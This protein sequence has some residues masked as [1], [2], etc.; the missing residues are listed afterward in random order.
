M[1]VPAGV[2]EVD[3]TVAVNGSA[4]D[5]TIPFTALHRLPSATPNLETTLAPGELITGFHV[6]AGPWTKRSLYLKIRDRQSYEFA[7]ASAAVALDMDG[8]KVREAR[9][10]LGGVATI[11]WR[12]REAEAALA[13]KELTEDTAQAAARAA[14]A[15]ATPRVHNAFKVALGRSTL[16]RALLQAAAMEG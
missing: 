10:A 16:V 14:F 7:L 6:P 8:S 12:S 15:G 11:P 13:G 1:T 2:P 9:I 3:A 4:G 5:R